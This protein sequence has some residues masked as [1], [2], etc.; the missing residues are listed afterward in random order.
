[1][2]ISKNW[3]KR[4]VDFKSSD[5]KLAEHLTDLGL[6][7]N[8]LPK[9]SYMNI[10]VGFVEECTEHPN[11]DRLKICNVN[12]GKSVKKIVCGA[13]NIKK[14]LFVPVA[15]PGA[16]IG[17]EKFEIK[18]AKIRGIESNGMICSGKEL[19]VNDDNT[20]IMCLDDNLQLGQDILT[21]LDIKDDTV[22]ELD[23]TPNR[24][25]CFSHLGIARE[26][27][28]FEKNA[29]KSIQNS[30]EKSD[31]AMSDMINVNIEEPSFCDRYSCKLI[32]NIRVIESP[33]WL[34]DF[35]LS[36]GQKP[37]NSIVDIA[38]FIM[39]DTGQPLHAFD[40][41]KIE[42]SNIIV[43][44]ANDKDKLV[45]INNIEYSLNKTDLVISDKN[46]PIAIAGVIGS[47]NSHV[48]K[49][50]V[51]IL[52]ES[53]VFNPISVRKTSKVCEISTESSKR[54]ERGVD[55]N[56]TKDAMDYFIR[57]VLEIS[58]GSVANDCVDIISKKNT[59]KKITFD[60]AKCNS[61]L[62]TSLNDEEMKNIFNSL[63]IDCSKGAHSFKCSIP[64]YRNDLNVEVDLY[65]EIARVYGYNNIA[66]TCYFTIS[67][68]AFH[69][70]RQ[71]IEDKLRL[72]LQALGFSEHY[73]NSFCNEEEVS[74]SN[75]IH[76]SLSPVKIKNPLSM[77]M[78]YLRCDLIPGLLRALSC[79][80]L[81]ALNSSLR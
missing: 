37:I 79:I 22:F 58:G 18:K 20:G 19:G 28:I 13:P 45:S 67:T 15:L 24:G 25:D 29:L 75:K 65:E 33:T 71:F 73:S 43:K 76:S 34:K 51:N 77:D 80:I 59:N 5:L 50:T 66:S 16:K 10:C 11:A 3:L 41:D 9:R 64:T 23:I 6:E 69:D 32:K 68:D 57:L 39:F 47:N 52:I 4:Y 35:L 21:A 26:I 61:F 48:D 49:E 46:K 53:A 38:N 55:I 1:M 17:L 70:D 2:K 14:G 63:N 54:F 31:F 7:C 60:V 42:G 40:F 72:N 74:I 62:G 36:I 44:F 78:N 30:Y 8:L 56:K 12:I 81:D 27:S